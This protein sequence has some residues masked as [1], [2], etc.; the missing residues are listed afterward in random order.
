MS[1]LP[2]TLMAQMHA[3]ARELATLRASHARLLEC[4]R[5]MVDAIDG[6]HAQVMATVARM[7][8]AIAAE[9][10]GAAG[11]TSP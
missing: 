7:S 11:R 5:E 1:E 10:F 9:S 6:S 8:A 3:Q 2:N 4:C